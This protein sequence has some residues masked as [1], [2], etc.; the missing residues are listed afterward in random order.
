MDNF[1]QEV[2]LSSVDY[3]CY[4]GFQSVTELSAPYC[5]NS[6][7][8]IVSGETPILALLKRGGLEKTFFRIEYD[9]DQE[10]NLLQMKK[11]YRENERSAWTAV[12][13]YEDFRDVFSEKLNVNFASF[14]VF[15]EKNPY[16]SLNYTN[17][18]VQFQPK[19]T[20]FLSL[21]SAKGT[22]VDFDYQFQTTV[23]SR[24]YSRE[25]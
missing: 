25:I 14:A 10:R 22:N 3:N 21:S 23:S 1:A 24:V 20:L 16:S 15:P 7:G 5:E 2:R 13:G 18:A 12:P 19:V 8:K 4:E 11:V 17:N 9:P 6:D